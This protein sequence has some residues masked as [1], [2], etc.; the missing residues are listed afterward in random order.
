[1]ESGFHHPCF[2][3]HLLIALPKVIHA[4][5][6]WWW[7]ASLSNLFVY[8]SDLRSGKSSMPL[9]HSKD[10]GYSVSCRDRRQGRRRDQ[11]P[12]KE[13]GRSDQGALPK[14]RHGVWNPA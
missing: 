11:G 6:T 13:G 4:S 10:T 7:K 9:S 12:G 5:V 1:M 2:L 14:E 3:E 8:K